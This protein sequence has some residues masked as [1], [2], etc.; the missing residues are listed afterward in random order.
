MGEMY[1]FE[2]RK[3]R[4]KKTRLGNRKDPQILTNDVSENGGFVASYE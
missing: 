4:L 1:D 2:R 3:I